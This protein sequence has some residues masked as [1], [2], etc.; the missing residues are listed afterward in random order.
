[1]L[2]AASSKLSASGATKAL[3]TSG[4]CISRRGGAWDGR[5]RRRFVNGISGSGHDFVVINLGPQLQPADVTRCRRFRPM[6]RVVLRPDIRESCLS[7][8]NWPAFAC[9]LSAEVDP[10][11]PSNSHDVNGSFGSAPA[12]RSSDVPSERSAAISS[13][14]AKFNAVTKAQ[15][16]GPVSCALT[17]SIDSSEHAHQT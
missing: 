12:V 7:D 13:T 1:V 4:G 15:A 14:T 9:Q 6:S 2:G 8:S 5:S 16:H 11:P 3:S 10:E 17:Q